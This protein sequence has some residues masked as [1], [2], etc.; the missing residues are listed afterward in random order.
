MLIDLT[1]YVIMRMHVSARLASAYY[2]SLLAKFP[3]LGYYGH[4][5]IFRDI[6]LVRATNAAF[7]IAALM[8]HAAMWREQMMIRRYFDKR[9]SRPDNFA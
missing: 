4:F 1:Y 7:C 9:A 3:H 6:L 2:A 8:M 5:H